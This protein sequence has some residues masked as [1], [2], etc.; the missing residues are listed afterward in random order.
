[1][2]N[3]FKIEGDIA[4]ITLTKGYFAK[5][6]VRDLPLISSFRWRTIV[7]KCSVY[8]IATKR[9]STGVFKTVFMHRLILDA[10]SGVQVDHKDGDGLNNL[11]SNLRLAT[12][13]QN[14]MNMRKHKKKASLKGASYD[15]SKNRWKAQI[16]RDRKAIYLGYF[17]SEIE[18]HYAYC[19]ASKKYHGEFGRTN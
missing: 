18:A 6:F 10:P 2:L 3:E 19:E 12:R 8:S 5:V 16:S 14:Q 15:K 9:V 4:I 17:D 7:Q 11:A 13:S 1:M